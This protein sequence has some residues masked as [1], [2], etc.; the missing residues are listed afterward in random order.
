MSQQA[1]RSRIIAELRAGHL[2]MAMKLVEDN[3]MD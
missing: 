3:A 1:I 2:G